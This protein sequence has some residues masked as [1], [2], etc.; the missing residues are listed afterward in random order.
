MRCD[1]SEINEAGMNMKLM[2]INHPSKIS[3]RAMQISW[4]SSVLV[5]IIV[6]GLGDP[7]QGAC[8]DPDLGKIAQG[9]K[10]TMCDGSLGVGTYVAPDLGQLSAGNIKAGVTIG[11]ITGT[12]SGTQCSSD[13]QTGC[14]TNSQ[15]PAVL[16]TSLSDPYDFRAK[17]GGIGKLKYCRSGFN[18]S[19]FDHPATPVNMNHI[20]KAFT[21][22]AASDTLTITGNTFLQS[23]GPA[24][25]KLTTT[26]TLPAPLTVGT[27]YYSIWVSSTT[28]KLAST[29]SAAVAAV[30]IDL[31]DAGSGVQKMYPVGDGVADYW[32][33]GN[34]LNS[35]TTTPG[36]WFTENYFGPEYLCTLSDWRV[37]APSPDGVTIVP[38]GSSD[39]DAAGDDCM[40]QDLLTKEIWTEV[41]PGGG[42]A[43]LTWAESR[44]FC[45]D[46]VF[47]GFSDWRLPQIK[48]FAQAYIDGLERT[49]YSYPSGGTSTSSWMWST[50]TQGGTPWD[51]SSNFVYGFYGSG[52]FQV[53]DVTASSGYA[54]R[55]VRQ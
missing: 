41:N 35:L 52:Q 4:R 27:T 21:A 51:N 1:A 5:V 11:T 49:E 33:V 15:Y 44:K 42:G 18:L 24:P 25:I 30:G 39:C 6:C 53:A 43:T 37:L 55:C 46:L 10:L 17:S 7:S 22:T 31:I 36:P 20:G 16:G 8:I 12:W 19:V 14:L 38:G 40:F 48:E 45:D 29:Y 54:T 13:N 9:T 50:T 28:I 26:G 32:D 34:S 2:P 47:G 23:I 3:R